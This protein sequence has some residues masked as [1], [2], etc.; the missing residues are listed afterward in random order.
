LRILARHFRYARDVSKH[1]EKIIKYYS[2]ILGIDLTDIN[3]PIS[4]KISSIP[5]SSEIDQKIKEHHLRTLALSLMEIKE[6]DENIYKYYIKRIK[7]NKDISV[8]GHFFE[9][10]QCAHFITISKENGLSFEFG[11]ANDNEPDF[12]VNKF[13]FEITSS[14]FSEESNKKN[15]GKKL[16]AKFREKNNKF[17]ADKDSVLIIDIN[18][19]SYHTLKNGLPVSPTFNEVREIIR[20]ESNFGLVI[21]LMEWIKKTDTIYFK[22]SAYAE[23]S[24]NC[25]SDLKIMMNEIFMPKKNKMNGEIIIT[26][27]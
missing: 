6:Y 8:H 26:P 22:G 27:N 19:M 5:S 14:R 1:M 24:E 23:Y 10:N 3:H 21:L 2:E 20:N 7:K 11:N 13:G 16:L 15:P 25:N 17:Y 9:I 18:Q 4:K 12:I